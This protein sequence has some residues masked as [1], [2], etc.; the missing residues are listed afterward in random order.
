MSTRTLAL[1]LSLIVLHNSMRLTVQEAEKNSILFFSKPNYQGTS[2]NVNANDPAMLIHNWGL[3]RSFQLGKNVKRVV[4]YQEPY[5]QDEG[6]TY[7]TSQADFQK[8]MLY[9][10]FKIKLE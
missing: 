2:W 9:S 8:N 4:F 3:A 1:F 7:T 10:S 5:F 6:P